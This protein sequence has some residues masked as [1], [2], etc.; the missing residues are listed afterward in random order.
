MGG[1]HSAALAN[2]W[3]AASSAAFL[4]MTGDAAH[5]E[6]VQAAV[7]VARGDKDTVLAG[8]ADGVGGEVVAARLVDDVDVMG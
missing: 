7:D 3:V 6:A 2:G 5:S 1:V 8:D 4:R